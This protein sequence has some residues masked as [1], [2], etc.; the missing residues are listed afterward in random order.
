MDKFKKAGVTLLTLGS[1]FALAAC[2]GKSYS[3]EDFISINDV[4]AHAKTL[5]SNNNNGGNIEKTGTANFAVPE[6]GYDGSEVEL[7]FYSTQ[8]QCFPNKRF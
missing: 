7:T 5:S 1:I 8:G 2:G 4:I 6:E 3:T